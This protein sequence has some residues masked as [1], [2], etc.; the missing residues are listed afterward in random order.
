MRRVRI[1]SIAL[2]AAVALVWPVMSATGD[3]SSQTDPTG[4]PVG[5]TGDVFI[6]LVDVSH[7]DG[8][9]SVSWS[10][11]T[12]SE[13]DPEVGTL[14][15]VRWDLDLNSNGTLNESVDACILLEPL[16]DGTGRI[17]AGLKA[18]C[19][20]VVAGTADAEVAGAVVTVTFANEFFR[21]STGFTGTDYQYQVVSKDFGEWNDRVPDDDATFIAHSSVAQPGDPDPTDTPD[22]QTP[23][24]TPT[25]T[26]SGATPTPT[27]TP[28][29]GPNDTSATGTPSKSTVAPGEPVTLSSEA[30]FKQDASLTIVMNSDPVTLASISANSSG[31]FSATVTIPST[32]IAGSHNIEVA[33]TN[34]NNGIHRLTFPITVAVASATTSPLASTA[35]TGGGATLPN[36]GAS[37]A[38]LLMAASVLLLLGFE[39]LAKTERFRRQG[40]T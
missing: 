27:P 25:P 30:G 7:Q 20:I 2:L 4:D 11:E 24:P 26:P 13:F 10:F 9:T 32:A 6:D 29:P 36:T 18:G 39:I 19:G 15:N 1:I 38:T 17:R 28:T 14:D 40:P 5:G 33:G 12:A 8:G 35:S 37:I 21:N 22:G 23:T 34:T 31:G 3:A 16:F